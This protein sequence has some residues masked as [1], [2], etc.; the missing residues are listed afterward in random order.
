MNQHLLFT[1]LTGFAIATVSVTLI[2]CWTGLGGMM[3][4]LCEKIQDMRE[5]RIRLRIDQ[6]LAKHGLTN[7]MVIEALNG[8]DGFRFYM[9]GNE[10]IARKGSDGQHQFM[11]IG[12]GQPGPE[13]SEIPDG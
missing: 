6:E 3:V 11:F 12:E 2:T 7:D 5:R 13:V 10:C 1:L 8:M 4:E 9:F